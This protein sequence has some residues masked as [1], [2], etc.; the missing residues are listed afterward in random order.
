MLAKKSSNLNTIFLILDFVHYKRVMSKQS[1]KTNI[2]F[3]IILS[4]S[5]LNNALLVINDIPIYMNHVII[6]VDIVD[7]Y[8]LILAPVGLDVKGWS[9][10][11]D[12]EF[13]STDYSC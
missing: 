7:I 6:I 10:N 8:T 12:T 5:D 1:N 13:G 11:S 3:V 9:A 2:T 4:S